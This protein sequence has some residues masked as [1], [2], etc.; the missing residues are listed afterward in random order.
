MSGGVGV[1][2]RPKK[3]NDVRDCLQTRGNR[4]STEPQVQPVEKEMLD[5]MHMRRKRQ[6][7]A[8]EAIDTDIEYMK[9]SC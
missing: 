6:E 1:A 3:G 5:Q 2:V 8:D 9:H 4:P 7:R